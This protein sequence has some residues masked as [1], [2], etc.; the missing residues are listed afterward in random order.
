MTGLFLAEIQEAASIAGQMTINPFKNIYAIICGLIW[1]FDADAE[2]MLFMLD[3]DCPIQNTDFNTAWYQLG[4]GEYDYV[5]A[6]SFIQTVMPLIPQ[7][8]I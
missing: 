6:S 4:A 1:T 3:T 8:Y 7:T 2:R 5:P